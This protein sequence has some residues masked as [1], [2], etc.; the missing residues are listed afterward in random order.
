MGSLLVVSAPTV[1]QPPHTPSGPPALR[2][3]HGPAREGRPAGETGGHHE[4]DEPSRCGWD[5]PERVRQVIPLARWIQLMRDLHDDAEA[6]LASEEEALGY[7]SCVS[8]E[9]P[10]DRDWADIFF[11]LGL[12]VFPRWNMLPDG[13]SACEAIGSSWLIVL[14]RQQAEDLRRFR[15]WLREKIEGG[16]R[17]PI[18]QKTSRKNSAAVEVQDEPDE[19]VADP[20]E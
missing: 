20:V 6:D 8:L 15:R 9:A 13:R 4:F 14:N 18:R 11:Y 1:P 3:G 5:Y 12:Q 17:K 2:A 10:L 7:L 16:G 19:P